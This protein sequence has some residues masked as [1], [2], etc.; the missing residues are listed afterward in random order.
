MDEP[1][2]GGFLKHGF[3]TDLFLITRDLG[4]V[5]RYTLKIGGFPLQP[6]WLGESP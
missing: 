1:F 5:K 4:E 6:T 2:H 3:V